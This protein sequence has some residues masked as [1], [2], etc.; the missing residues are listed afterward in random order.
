MLKS[1]QLIDKY[2]DNRGWDRQNMLPPVVI[3][4]IIG[5]SLPVHLCLQFYT[6]NTRFIGLLSRQM[7]ER[8]REDICLNHSF[9]GYGC[10]ENLSSKLAI[11]F[12]LGNK[13]QMFK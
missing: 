12:V 6:F 9:A 2:C 1:W 11:N 8:C 5:P 4:V 7:D 13:F 10:F 3:A